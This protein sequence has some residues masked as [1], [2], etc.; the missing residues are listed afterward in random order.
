[1]ISQKDRMFPLK[2]PVLL[3]SHFLE[4]LLR[5]KSY[6]FMKCWDSNDLDYLEFSC[7]AK[8]N[9]FGR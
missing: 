9:H 5:V 1:M 3:L 6:H 4:P 2:I 7:R 8:V